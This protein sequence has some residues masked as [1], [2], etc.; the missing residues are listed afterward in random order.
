MESLCEHCN[1]LCKSQENI[2]ILCSPAGYKA[3]KTIQI[4]TASAAN[5]CPLCRML[6]DPLYASSRW[7]GK[8]LEMPETEVKLNGSVDEHG[9]VKTILLL[10]KNPWTGSWDEHM[11][12]QVNLQP[13]KFSLN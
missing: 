6:V 10:T 5:G 11:S 9:I 7:Y 8:V 2:D 3:H 13:G 12:L 1:P 4:L